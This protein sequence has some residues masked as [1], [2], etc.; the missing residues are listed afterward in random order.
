MGRVIR[1]AELSSK[2]EPL[3][4]EG[5]TAVARTMAARDEAAELERVARDRIVELAL[6]IA[7]RIVGESVAAD[8]GLLDRIYERALARIGELAPVSIR[9]HPDDRTR[10]AIDTLAATRG[11]DV[12]DDPSVGRAGCRV[13]ACGVEVDATLEAALAV[14]RDEMTGRARG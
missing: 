11:V 9:V 1:A 13:E 8:P 2:P 6:A 12:V 10:S 4:Q 3:G 14:L 5:R 7:G